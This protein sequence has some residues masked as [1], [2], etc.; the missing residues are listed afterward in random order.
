MEASLRKLAGEL[1]VADRVFFPGFVDN[2][3]W[4]MAQSDAFLLSSQA[5][6]SPLA[7]VEAMAAGVPVVSTDCPSGPS[8]II[9][10][11]LDGR[12]V[13]VGAVREFADAV[14][15]TL[16]QSTGR[17][18]EQVRRARESIERYH[19]EIALK[20]YLK[21]LGP[22]VALDLGDAPSRQ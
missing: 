18:E 1:G 15:E 10:D 2:P 12:L 22:T 14:Q 7:L 21:L 19:P 17:R 13:Q 9:T 16:E 3:W 8:E 20:Q 5:E 6:G 11:G 4:F